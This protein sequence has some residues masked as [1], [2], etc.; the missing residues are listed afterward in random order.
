MAAISAGIVAGDAWLDL[1]YE[2]DVAAEVDMNV[3]MNHLGE[4]V[5]IQATGEQGTLGRGQLDTLLELAGR[6]IGELMA[7]QRAVLE[8]GGDAPC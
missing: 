6:G 3:A 1:D 8:G 2:L 5:E 7:L 4:F